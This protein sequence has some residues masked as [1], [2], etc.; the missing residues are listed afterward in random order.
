MTISQPSKLV[1]VVDLPQVK[2]FD[3]KFVYNFFTPDE[4][5]NDTGGVPTRALARPA[6]AINSDFIQWSLTRVPR[7]VDFS[8]SLPSI[9][10][11]GNQVSAQAQ[12][13]NA[14]KTSGAQH[15][16][17]IG[18]NI[19]KVI[20]EDYF[21]LNGFVA[22]SFHD[23]EID[24]KIHYLVSGTLM[25]QA[26]QHAHADSNSAHKNAQSLVTVLPD[27]IK[28]HF[29]FQ[30]L[31]QPAK[32]SGSQ[33]YPKQQKMRRATP[34]HH[35][36]ERSIR[37]LNSYLEGLKKVRTNAQVN[38]KLLLGLVNGVINDPTSTTAADVVSMHSYA[39]QA[40]QATNQRVS[41]GLA[42]NDYKTFVPF[43]SVKKQPVGA[44]HEKY[45]SELV[46]FII[47]KFE[48]LPDGSMKKLDPIILESPH[49]SITADFR[50]KF[51]S[52]YC[53]TIRSIAQLTL[54]A[55]DSSTGDVAT[56]KVLVSS[57]PSSKA[58]VST[59]KLD[60]PPPPGDVNFVF[61]WET[62]KM[63]VTW[64][65]PVWS[66]QDIAQFQ[67]FRRRSVDE[68]FQ[69]LKVYN[70]DTSAIRFP[71]NERPD[72]RVIER[73]TSPCQFYI[74]DGFDPTVN[75]SEAK[76]FIYAV[77][78]V[79]AHGLSS[80]LSAQFNVWF[81][82]F[83]NSLQ[84]CHI[85]HL[86]APKSYPNLYLDGDLFVNTI[87]VGGPHSRSMKLYFNPDYYYLYDDQGRT[88]PVLA[89]KQRGGSYRLQFINKDS[90]EEAVVDVT[91]DDQVRTDPGILSTPQRS[92]GPQ[93]KNT[94][95]QRT[96]A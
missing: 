75:I 44:H 52:M 82:P 5:T 65:V 34:T 67:V 3:A 86:G 29:L 28:P 71:D 33:F 70:F 45:S 32:E 14:N 59:T 24:D 89:T 19:D 85:S 94:V 64:A 76:G 27:N 36:K 35:P 55:I 21:S 17:L 66:Q 56:I 10:D 68:P 72:P 91:I 18:D 51:H 90:G 54:P 83:R 84:K 88:Q 79:D 26:L 73:L 78:C 58:Y 42:E 57:K 40:K 80:C 39:K 60:A 74:D 96:S 37:Y 41:P 20:D 95:L 16:S 8:F 87:N 38:S 4:C 53:Y 12:R 61:N 50:V 92:L 23:G 62:Q 48:V 1:Y 47:D 81:D 11:V 15:G 69:L 77:T 13:N 9:A 46:G 31:A 63:M 25:T 22:V 93:A 43:I 6:T 7:E 30:A 49:A 2:N